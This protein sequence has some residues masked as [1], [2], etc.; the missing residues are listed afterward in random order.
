[1]LRVTNETRSPKTVTLSW[2]GEFNG[3]ERENFPG[4]ERNVWV[5]IVQ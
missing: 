2:L 1:M 4:S 5:K 3:A